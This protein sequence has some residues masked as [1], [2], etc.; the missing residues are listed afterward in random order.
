[1]PRAVRF[2]ETGGPDVLRLEDVEVREPG[3]GEVRIRTHALGVNRAEAMFRAGQYLQDPVLPA[4]IGYEAAG[5]VESVGPDVD[6]AVGARVAV[7]PAF[8]MNDYPQ[9]GELVLA[10]ARAV[11]ELPG[12]LSWID[13][14]AS[15]MQYATAWGGLVAKGGL[16]KGDTVLIP[17][18]SSSVGL[19]AIQIAFALGAHPVA[20]THSP[21]KESALKETGAD[22][23]VTSEQDLAE[24]VHRL[25]D[26][27]GARVAFDAVGGPQLPA[28]TAALASE[29]VV[30]IYGALSTEQTPLPVMDML[31]KHLTI[32]GFELFEIT[33]DDEG[34]ASAVD[35]MQRGLAD[36]SLHPVVDRTFALDDVVA[37]HEYLESNAQ[38]GKVVL[39]VD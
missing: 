26:G 15:A 24:E 34:L 11:I 19:A 2:H 6:L 13:A 4:G 32:R 30:V 18:A 38:F 35:F 10:P 39:T 20:I 25:T 29:G 27:A 7:V 16:A 9:H 21:K 8:T 3:P 1:M 14:A 12:D 31:G 33:N 22:V 28:I 17:A 36:G 37:A 23:I 5:E